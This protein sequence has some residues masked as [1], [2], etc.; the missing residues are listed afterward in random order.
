MGSLLIFTGSG[1]DAGGG[2]LLDT[3]KCGRPLVCANDVGI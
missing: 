2:V 3:A 1:E